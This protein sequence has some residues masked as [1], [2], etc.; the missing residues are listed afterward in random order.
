MYSREWRVGP[1]QLFIDLVIIIVNLL[2]LC[3]K[4]RRKYRNISP[5]PR[6]ASSGWRG[7]PASKTEEV[8]E[9][10]VICL[11]ACR[12]GQEAHDDCERE[13]T[14]TKCFLDVIKRKP[15]ITW[16]ELRDSLKQLVSEIQARYEE[17][18]L[19]GLIDETYECW[20]QEPRFSTSSHADLTRKISL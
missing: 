12:E 16:T 4:C 17:K 5:P 1:G 7:P 3:K 9:L 11:S 13:L 2:K 14:F 15:N 8:G 20:A 10:S 18:W 19:E 6:R